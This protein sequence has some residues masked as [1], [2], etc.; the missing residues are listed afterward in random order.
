MAP[1]ATRRVSVPV[2]QAGVQQPRVTR[3]LNLLERVRAMQRLFICLIGILSIYAAGCG[4]AT[5]SARGFRLPD[6]DVERGKTAFVSLQCHLCHQVD[7]I[8]LPAPEKTPT[9]TVLLGGEVA[10]VKTYGDLVTSIIHPSHKLATR[11]KKEDVS[12]DGKSLMTNCN[13]I[14]TVRQ[15]IDLVA[16]LQPRFR[17]LDLESWRYQ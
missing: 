11:Y 10:N 7:G 2:S 13:E 4:P 17:R 9:M 8:E 5:K 12:R 6:G 15:M 14:M 3:K 1:S 16:F